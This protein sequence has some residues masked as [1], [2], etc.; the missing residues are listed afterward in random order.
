MGFHRPCA[1][2]SCCSS[3]ARPCSAFALPRGQA[4]R[5]AR[6]ASRAHRALFRSAAVL[7]RAVRGSGGR[8]GVPAPRHHAAADGDVSQ[9][10]L[11]ERLAAPDPRREP[12]SS[13]SRAGR[14]ARHRRRRLGRGDEPSRQHHR[15]GEADGRRQPRHGVD[16]ERDRQAA[17]RLESRRRRA[18]GERG[19]LVNHL[20]SELLPERADGMRYA[21]ADPVTGQAAWYDLRVRIRKAARCAASEPRFAPQSRAA[22]ACPSG[23]T[24]CASAT[25][26]GGT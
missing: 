20:I 17:R 4:W 1:S 12:A 14:V 21:N 3:T 9:L 6:A 7:V 25:R 2:R 23:R 15:A 26:A 22:R 16:L 13:P 10:G 8:R 11:A 5:A 24:C 19:F 18:R